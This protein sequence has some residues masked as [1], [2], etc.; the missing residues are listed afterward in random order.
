MCQDAD[1]IVREEKK[2]KLIIKYDFKVGL[3]MR[4][5]RVLDVKLFCPTAP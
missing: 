3:N 2:A 1:C 5:S 4:M